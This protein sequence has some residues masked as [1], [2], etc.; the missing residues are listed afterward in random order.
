MCF[1]F[2]AGLLCEFDFG[3]LVYRFSCDVLVFYVCVVFCLRVDCWFVVIRLGLVLLC[4]FCV[5]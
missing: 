1:T 3:C 5:G 4:L 2:I